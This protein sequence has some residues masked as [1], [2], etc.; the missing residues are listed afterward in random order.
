M[1]Y[2]NGAQRV[3]RDQ[4][5]GVQVPRARDF[6]IPSWCSREPWVVELT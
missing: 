1:Q 5:V 4:T 3:L 2:S 6:D